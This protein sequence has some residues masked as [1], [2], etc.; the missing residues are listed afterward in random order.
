MKRRINTIENARL[1]RKKSTQAEII[2]LNELRNKR[3]RNMKFRRQHPLDRYIVDFY[4][5]EKK[6]IFEVDGLIHNKQE[7]IVYDSV[8][9]F[10]LEISGYKIIRLKNEDILN[11]VKEVLEKTII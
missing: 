5:H 4:C 3:F 11:N 2:L 1:L 9:Q 6:L 7:Q 8:R 10:E